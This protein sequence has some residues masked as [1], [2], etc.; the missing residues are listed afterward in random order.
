[1]PH[2]Q[3]RTNSSWRDWRKKEQTRRQSATLDRERIVRSDANSMWFRCW[4]ARFDIIWYSTVTPCRST[5]RYGPRPNRDVAVSQIFWNSLTFVRWQPK[6]ISPKLIGLRVHYFFQHVPRM[7]IYIRMVCR[8]PVNEECWSTLFKK[9][10]GAGGIPGSF[11]LTFLA[12]V[13]TMDSVSAERNK[14]RAGAG[15]VCLCTRPPQVSAPA[16][17][18]F[19]ISDRESP[20]CL[21]CLSSRPAKKIEVEREA[22]GARGRELEWGGS[23]R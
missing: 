10:W 16:S 13:E 8:E 2:C 4:F 19:L 1:M 15:M 11:Q 6:S 9:Q 12:G 7:L 22:R 18:H 21:D 3:V 23:R 14:R 20:A 17:S 5:T